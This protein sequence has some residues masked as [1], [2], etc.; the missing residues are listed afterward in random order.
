MTILL[1]ASGLALATPGTAFGAAPHRS[2][3]SYCD[4][5]VRVMSYSGK[6]T[7]RRRVLY[8]R[9]V[10]KAPY[11]VRDIA[12][13][14]RDAPAGSERATKAHNLWVYFNNNSCCE[15]HGARQAPQIADF[16]PEQ[17]MRV[18]AGQPVD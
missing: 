6:S 4:A 15:C 9:V 12:R 11:M 10:A 3:G 18:E 8:N 1:V 2:G 14:V 7:A 13:D 17:R 16:T 5:V